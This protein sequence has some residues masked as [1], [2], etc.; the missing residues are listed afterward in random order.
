MARDVPG[1]RSITLHRRRAILGN[2]TPTQEGSSERLNIQRSRSKLL[3]GAGTGPQILSGWKQ[4]APFKPR[5]PRAVGELGTDGPKFR[6]SSAMKFLPSLLAC[7]V[8]VLSVAC[9]NR[10]T[11]EENGK[12]RIIVFGAHPDDAQFKAGGTAAKWT[13]AGHAV[14]LI[15]VTNGDIG[16]W[17]IAGGPLAQRRLAE[18][19][20]A[21]AVIGAATE[22]L[23]I[24]DGE[25]MPTLEN[26]HTIIRLIRE[27]KADIVIAHRPWDYHPDHRYVGVLIQDAAFMV[28]VPFV[29]PDVPPLKKN[30]LFLYSSDRFQK[31]Y[32]FHADIAV[33]VDEVFEKKL[34][35]I[36][37]MPSQV[38]E[39]GANGSAEYV[40]TV[41]PASDEPGRKLWLRK[42][43]E[44]RQAEEADRFRAVL[45]KYYGEEKGLAVK[46]AEAFEIC[47]Y[48]R[49]P[50]AAEIRQLFPFFP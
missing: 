10:S 44:A 47:E 11:A 42:R 27:W 38:Y 3:D 29:C 8:I 30:P 46:Y 24:H 7:A 40:K 26:R 16:H 2:D 39:G 17:E 35:A 28:T 5:H 45:V 32:P 1:A 19:K 49:Q 36:H 50:S 34:A 43:W 23:D 20:K 41:P 18:V 31:P 14:K 21:D 48:G 9:P 37:E 25:L 15:S 12:L 22:V 13:A 33:A 4:T 6:F